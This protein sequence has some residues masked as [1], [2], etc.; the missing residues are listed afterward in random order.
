MLTGLLAL[1][2]LVIKLFP[3]TAL[4]RSLHRWLVEWPVEMAGRIERKHIILVV[5]LLCA[6]QTLAIAGSAELALA[7]AMDM[8]LYLDTMLAAFIAAAAARLKAAAAAFRQA[9]LSV[10]AR[11]RRPR[12]RTRRRRPSIPRPRKPSNDD[13]PVEMPILQAA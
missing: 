2:I 12:P 7:Y 4:A 8:S 5:I 13:H 3:D 10:A 11:I 6:G 9:V 1:V